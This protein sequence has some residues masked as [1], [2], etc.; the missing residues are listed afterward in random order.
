MKAEDI[1]LLLIVIVVGAAVWC[2]V[3]KLS[4]CKPVCKVVVEDADAIWE[5]DSGLSPLLKEPKALPRPLIEYPN[6]ASTHPLIESS[7]LGK[8]AKVFL[9]PLIEYANSAISFALEK[10]RTSTAVLPRPLIEYSDSTLAMALEGP[11]IPPTTLPRPLVEY[12]DS[13]V[14]FVLEQPT[15]ADLLFA[16]VQPRPVVEYADAGW[17]GS[18]SPP[19]GL[20]KEGE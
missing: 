7:K 2:F 5:P 16:Q 11:E 4:P 9:R 6:A 14:V 19:L 13:V 10:P 20:L 1:V 18:L 8:K 12:S 3:L 15:G 17:S